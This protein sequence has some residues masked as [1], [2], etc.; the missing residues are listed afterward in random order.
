[1]SE[2]T[3]ALIVAIVGASTGLA[4]LAW[5]VISWQR[6]GPSVTLDAWFENGDRVTARAWNTG[7]SDAHISG[8]GF[9][10]FEPDLAG[11]EVAH[12]ASVAPGDVTP[13]D[14]RVPANGSLNVTITN[15]DVVLGALQS[16]LRT[17]QKV[18]PRRWVWLM[19]RT[20]PRETVSTPVVPTSGISSS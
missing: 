16:S 18:G 17:G 10:W 19:A 15:L 11:A 13:D 5:N 1:M 20:G 12:R 4:A 3:A 7:R 8:F 14:T 2:A 6:Q 9:T